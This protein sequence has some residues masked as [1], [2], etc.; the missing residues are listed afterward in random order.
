LPRLLR[1]DALRVVPHVCYPVAMTLNPGKLR[2]KS[3][4]ELKVAMESKG[5]RTPVEVV[6]PPKMLARLDRMVASRIKRKPDASRSTVITV[7]VR[8]ALKA[9]RDAKKSKQST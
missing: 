4:A 2:K 1:D 6:F 8:E 7:L 5:E 9:R 3:A